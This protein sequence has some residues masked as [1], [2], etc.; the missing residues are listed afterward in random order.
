MSQKAERVARPGNPIAIR[1][2][3]TKPVEIATTPEEIQ[4]RRVARLFLV[5]PA[6]A[7]TIAHLAYGCSP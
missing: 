6:T 4:R 3:L 2:A 5:S 1:I 7:A